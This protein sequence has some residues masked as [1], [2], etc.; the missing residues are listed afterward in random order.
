MTASKFKRL[1]LPT[2][3]VVGGVTVGSFVA[4][5]GLASADENDQDTADSTS[6]STADSESGTVTEAPGAD[7]DGRQGHGH[8]P[9]RRGPGFGERVEVLE[10]LLGLTGQ[11]IHDQLA[12]GNTLADVA[13]AQGVSVDELTTALVDAISEHIDQAVADGRLDADEAE[14]RKADLEDRVAEM[15]SNLPPEGFGD[16]PEGGPDGR[17]GRP[18]LV[19]GGS[20]V[21]E[22]VLGLTAEE[23]RQ[24]LDDGKTLAELAEE[25]GVSVDDVADALVAE[26]T[27]RIDQAVEDGKLD[28]DRAAQAKENLED[29]VDRALEAEPFALGRHVGRAEG[30]AFGRHHG[31]PGGPDGS[32]QPA[33]DDSDTTTDSSSTSS[34]EVVDT[35]F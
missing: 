17:P 13:E 9:G 30:R 20:E 1:A 24:G 10:D 25:Q 35:S 28:A 14:E 31:G 23:I 6:D 12:E 5:I 15:V 18:G 8:G 16:R 11:E 29:M 19:P 32:G 34:G 22:D 7:V 21:L 27:E 33:P 3:L 4:P 2:A 26:A